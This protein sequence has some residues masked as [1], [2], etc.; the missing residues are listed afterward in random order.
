VNR[1]IDTGSNP[2]EHVLEKAM[3]VL[4]QKIADI[5]L[6]LRS[7][8]ATA[9]APLDCKLSTIQDN[10]RDVLS[11]RVPVFINA[12]Y[13]S[14]SQHP[15]FTVTSDNANMPPHSRASDS[16][17]AANVTPLQTYKMSRGI[18]TVADL[19][20]EWSVGL[21]GGPAIQDLETRLG[22]RW[23]ESNEQRFYNR[24]KKISMKSRGVLG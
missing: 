24:R 14:I 11:G 5:H 18:K 21:S 8:I 4:S 6:D 16:E 23:C 2:T 9:I 1:C 12:D 17:P 19:W 22:A 20:R 3:P 15:P 7:A 13:N 10:I